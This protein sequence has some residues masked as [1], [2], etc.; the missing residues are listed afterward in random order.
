MTRTFAA[1][2]IALSLLVAGVALACGGDEKV[3]TADNTL[4]DDASLAKV[5]LTVSDATCG[6]CV[7]GIRKELTA[8]NGVKSVEGSEDDFHDV[9]VTYTVGAVT[10]DELI[11]AVKKAGYTAAVKPTSKTS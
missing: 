7:V 4:L 10:T 1:F 5:T 2:A 9:F 11:A 8:L 6:G 3:E